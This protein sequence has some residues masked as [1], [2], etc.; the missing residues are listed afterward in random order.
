MA[1]IV[2]TTQKYR[3]KVVDEN[4]TILYTT[5]CHNDKN[6]CFQSASRFCEMIQDNQGL[7]GPLRVTFERK[8][9]N[10]WMPE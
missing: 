10:G 2:K 3:A 5:V 8:T 9:V 1:S 6:A 7:Q 4:M